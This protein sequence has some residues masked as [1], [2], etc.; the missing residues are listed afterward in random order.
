M[1]ETHSVDNKPTQKNDDIGKLED[2]VPEEH[3]EANT[4]EDPEEP[5]ID[6]ITTPSAY[7]IYPVLRN[8]NMCYA[9][10]LNFFN[11]GPFLLYVI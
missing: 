1:K 8:I 7:F 4:E 5:G 10:I 9:S 3:Y 6:F 11:T 2:S